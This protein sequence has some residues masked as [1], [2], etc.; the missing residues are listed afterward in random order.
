V[1]VEVEVEVEVDVDVGGRKREG[2]GGIIVRVGG[3]DWARGRRRT[4][5]RRMDI[6]LL[7]TVFWGV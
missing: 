5:E 7:I 2:E 6:L 3:V 4:R 1:E